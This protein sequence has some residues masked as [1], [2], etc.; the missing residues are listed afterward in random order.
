MLLLFGFPLFVDYLP[1]IPVHSDEI[2]ISKFLSINYKSPSFVSVRRSV[3]ARFPNFS[4][5]CSS[6]LLAH[7]LSANGCIWLWCLIIVRREEHE[8]KQLMLVETCDL[9]IT[10]FTSQ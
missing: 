3:G 1:E 2:S 8:K 9:G 10:G 4:F 6:P 5:C 7:W